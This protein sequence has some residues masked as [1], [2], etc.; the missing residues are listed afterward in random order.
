VVFAEN[1]CARQSD[2][3]DSVPDIE[4]RE[5]PRSWVLIVFSLMQRCAPSSR[6][7]IPIGRRAN[8]SLSR[9]V[10]RI[11][12]PGQPSSGAIAACFDRWTK[13]P[14]HHVRLP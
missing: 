7:V 13:V 2:S 3:L 9:S 14:A 12:R 4:L 6:L 5:R 11:S 10:R 8:S 1:S